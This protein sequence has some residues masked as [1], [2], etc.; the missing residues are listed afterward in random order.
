[1]SQVELT[2]SVLRS[3]Y[4]GIHNV[5]IP[6]TAPPNGGA[7]WNFI[8]G[9]VYTPILALVKVSALLFLLRL[10]GTKKRVR[11]ACHIMITFNLL[12]LFT[13]LPL[14]IVQCLPVHAPWVTTPGSGAA[15]CLRRDIYAMAQAIANILTDILTLLIP[16]FVFLDLRV[17]RRVRIALMSIFML[18]AM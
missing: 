10:G 12:Q 17:N 8:N 13:F 2:R 5:D 18:G 3:G 1:M 9:V 7:F 6:K 11:L 16:F 15:S 14:A 4:W